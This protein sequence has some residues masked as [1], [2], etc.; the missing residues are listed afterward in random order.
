MLD[1]LSAT[2]LIC[3][4]NDSEV[5]RWTPQSF[6]YC[7]RGSCESSMS[8][9]GGVLAWCVSGV[10]NATDDLGQ[11]STGSC[12]SGT[13]LSPQDSCLGYPPSGILTPVAHTVMSS[14]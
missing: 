3:L 4:L 8:M 10:N 13:Q 1:T 14:V 5:S 11:R 7:T 12:P 6:G 2:W 9:F